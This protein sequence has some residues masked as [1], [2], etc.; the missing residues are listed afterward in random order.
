MTAYR[1]SMLRIYFG[2]ILMF[3]FAKMFDQTQMEAPGFIFGGI[4]LLAILLILGYQR[5]MI[6]RS[7][8]FFCYLIFAFENT[9]LQTN[10]VI[11][12]CI[13]AS[14]SSISGHEPWR[15]LAK[16]EEIEA[17]NLKQLKISSLLLSLTIG[18]TFLFT[19]AWT[20]LVPSDLGSAITWSLILLIF[21]LIFPGFLLKPRPLFP[22]PILFFDGVCGLCNQVVNFVFVEDSRSVFNVATLQG[23][24]AKEKLPLELRQSLNSVVVLNHEGRLFQK[25][26]AILNILYEIGGFWRLFFIFR[27]IPRPITD[28]LYIL[29][30][31]FRYSLFGKSENCRLPKPEERQKFLS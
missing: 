25:S 6:S 26:E 21:L 1:F 24:T 8:L 7:L 10:N 20:F 27:L 11:I 18:C 29:V 30:A 19:Y 15:L 12:L 14:F 9:I 23:E 3:V 16:N 17:L 22:A 2:I 31:K 4:T 5:E 28:M 13:L